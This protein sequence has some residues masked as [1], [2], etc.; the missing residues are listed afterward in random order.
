M[1]LKLKRGTE[2]DDLNYAVQLLQKNKLIYTLRTKVMIVTCMVMLIY[3]CC[4]GSTDMRLRW[5][6]HTT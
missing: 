2:P 5:K 3:P 6:F 4:Y 1:V